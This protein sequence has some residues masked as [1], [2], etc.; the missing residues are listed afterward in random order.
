MTI[1]L[2]LMILIAGIFIGVSIQSFMILIDK[3]FNKFTR[4][5]PVVV[6]II[7]LILVYMSHFQILF[8][9]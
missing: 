2:Y 8:T 4:I 5:L 9:P 1:E 6:F 3:K 7:G